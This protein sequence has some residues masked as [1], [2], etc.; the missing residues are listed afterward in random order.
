[1]VARIA[2]SYPAA[3]T[4]HLVLDNLNSHC[5]K[6]L[7][8][9]Y[10]EEFGDYL[11]KRFS[12]H[13]TP[14]HGSWLNQAE[15]EISLFSRQCLGRRLAGIRRR[16]RCATADALDVDERQRDAPGALAHEVL[17]DPDFDKWMA[18]A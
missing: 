10:G 12:V 18:E 11:W 6:S 16:H 15:I 14:K 9:C 5:R 8:G 2:I 17:D 4:I 13:Y 7:V 1:M 3:K